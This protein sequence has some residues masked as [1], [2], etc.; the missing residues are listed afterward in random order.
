MAST[1][2]YAP[3][4][5]EDPDAPTTSYTQAPPSYQVPADGPSAASDE[6]RLFGGAPRDSEDNLPDDFK[7][8]LHRV[9]HPRCIPTPDE[10]AG[11]LEEMS[12]ILK[13]RD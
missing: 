4:P 12:R 13:A 10:T 1:A 3:A 2:K 6:A 9:P 11:G 7:V 8:R 5:T